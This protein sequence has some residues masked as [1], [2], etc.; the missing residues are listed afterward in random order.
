MVAVRDLCSE[1][2]NIRVSAAETI[3]VGQ[4]TVS[5]TDFML[6]STASFVVRK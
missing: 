6:K 5:S 3:L 1:E 4:G 2:N